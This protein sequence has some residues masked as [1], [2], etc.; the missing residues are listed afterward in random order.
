MNILEEFKRSVIYHV[1]TGKYEVL[2]TGKLRSRSQQEL[3][4]SNSPWFPTVP[5]L[6]TIPQVKDIAQIRGGCGLPNNIQGKKLGNT[7]LVRVS[8]MN[9]S[10][11][12]IHIDSAQSYLDEK[13]AKKLGQIILTGSIIFPKVG[14]AIATNKR[15]IL[16]RNCIIDNNCGA[17]IPKNINSKLLY[18]IMLQ[19]PLEAL[20]NG[21]AVPS[22][23]ERQL[24]GIIL[25]LPPPEEATRIL[26]F[27]E[28]FEAS[29]PKVGEALELLEAWKKSMIYHVVTGKYEVTEDGN[30]R[31]RKTNNWR[32]HRLKDLFRIETGMYDSAEGKETGEIPFYRATRK[33][34]TSWHTEK[35]HD[36]PEYIILPKGGGS[37]TNVFGDAVAMGTSFLVQ[38]KTAVTHHCYVIIPKTKKSCPKWLHAQ[39]SCR[40]QD[41]NCLANFTTGLGVINTRTME[42]FMVPL[43]PPEEA[44]RILVFL[45]KLEAETN[46]IKTGWL[47]KQAETPE[48]TPQNENNTP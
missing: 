14:A 30:V 1:V 10:I 41:V 17:I 18:F 8:D 22:I 47:P 32:K 37:P 5:K 44:T 13:D 45:E 34:P 39:L 15:R 6:W 33:N 42:N 46:R 23:N 38:G 9:T 7:P 25:P 31:E 26:A 27:L 2:P 20:E 48:E 29:L 43:P 19:I 24:K 12:G 3:K 11:D 21:G 4:S 36:Y 35:S 16:K 40:K 28:S